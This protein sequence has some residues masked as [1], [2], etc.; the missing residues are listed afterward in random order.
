MKDPFLSRFLTICFT[1]ASTLLAAH[2]SRADEVR[3]SRDIGLLQEQI[4]RAVSSGQ[5]RVV[6]EP[7]IYRGRTKENVFLSIKGA[8]DLEIDARGVIMICEKLTRAIAVNECEDLRILGLTV[9]YDPIPFTQGT[10]VEVDAADKW[11]DVRI[12]EGY[13]LKPYSRLDIV[14]AEARH[15]KHGMPFVWG[16]KAEFRENGLLRISLQQGFK[17]SAAAGDLVSLSTGPEEGGIPHA[18]T[19][20]KSARL[21][22]K[23]FTLHSAPGFGIVNGGGYGDHHYDNVRVVPGHKP[24]GATEERLLS[25]SWDAIQFNDLRKGPI[26]E[27]SMVMSAG[28]DSWSLSS[29]DY[30]V[31]AAKGKTVWLVSRVSY[32][33]GLEAGDRLARS[34]DGLMPRII[35]VEPKKIPIE[36]CPISPDL[37]EKIRTAKSWDFHDFELINIRQA[38]LDMDYPWEPGISVYSPDRNCSGFVLRNNTFHSPGRAGLIN[39][40]SNGLIEGNTYMDCHSVLDIYPNLPGGGATGAKNIIFRNNLIKGTNHFCPAPWNLTAGAI[41]IAHAEPGKKIA[42]EGVYRDIVIN[43]NTFEQA[44]GPVFLITSTR[45]LRIADNKMIDCQHQPQLGSGESWGVDGATLGWLN[46][47]SDVRIEG[48]VIR[49]RGAFGTSEP[50]VII[51]NPVPPEKK[52]E[53]Q[54]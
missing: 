8:K 10:I 51:E 54:R 25:T 22:L 35:S 46:N 31:L 44:R 40:A 29:R 28:D 15:R 43:N 7:G 33:N 18:V 34:L 19:I 9:D 23:D 14:D 24:K 27:N 3:P 37:L 53:P 12:H 6:I 16:T 39:G 48:N 2:T 42:G 36:Q 21:T 1:A 45:G 50:F 47:N 41:N 11:M 13:P 20:E 26:M 30:L 4:S 17:K 32:S 52:D 38:E 5:K 49:N